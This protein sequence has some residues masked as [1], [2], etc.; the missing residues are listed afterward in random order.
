MSP[1]QIARYRSKAA[2]AAAAW[3]QTLGEAPTRHALILAMAV[4]DLETG[5]GNIRGHNWGSVHKRTLNEAESSIL[6]GH[7]V[8][9]TGND[10]LATARG[11]FAPTQA[12]DEL[13]V[14]DTSPIGPYFV[15]IWSFTSDLDAASKFLS[16]LVGNRP[17]VRAIID[18][19]SPTS[20][21]AA[22]Y[23]TRYF[24]GTSKDPREN[25][26][27]YAGHIETCAARIES[28]LLGWP[29]SSA[30][31]NAPAAPAPPL[32]ERRAGLGWWLAG[33]AALGIGVALIGRRA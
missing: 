17:P 25:I 1:D 11:L 29:P 16:I 22:M 6:L 14:I 2:T 18:S 33:I 5:L 21:A 8:Y 31:A 28:A 24:E 4:A 27:A 3:H 26:R 12:P 19:A 9:P 30:T 7:G 23:A 32:Q 20:L 13:L 15:W 10:A